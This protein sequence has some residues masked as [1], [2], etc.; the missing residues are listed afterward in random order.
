MFFWKRGC[1]CKGTNASSCGCGGGCNT[2]TLEPA[3]FPPE[4]TI[5]Y[6]RWS[7]GAENT[8]GYSTNIGSIAHDDFCDSTNTTDANFCGFCGECHNWTGGR[9]NP[10]VRYIAGGEI[11]ELELAKTVTLTL[12]D[13]TASPYPDAAPTACE[14]YY[15]GTVEEGGSLGTGPDDL[16]SCDC[17]TSY[18]WPGWMV[19][20][21]AHVEL[22]KDA[23]GKTKAK[24]TLTYNVI[25][26]G[27][28]GY[29]GDGDLATHFQG[30][31]TLVFEGVG[32]DLGEDI[33]GNTNCGYC[34]FP[35]EA[36]HNLALVSGG[37]TYPGAPPMAGGTVSVTE[38]YGDR[39]C[40]AYCGDPEPVPLSLDE[41]TVYWW[42]A[43][44][45]SAYGENLPLG[46]GGCANNYDNVMSHGVDYFHVSQCYPPGDWC[47]GSAQDPD[48]TCIGKVD[49]SQPQSVKLYNDGLFRRL[50]VSIS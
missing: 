42:L 18:T 17:D 13:G 22:I 6:T 39:T 38:S 3:E 46:E 50:N 26:S 2:G 33:N 11:D 15:R 19:C 24:V 9:G 36:W 40:S 31:G 7:L 16:M 49:T 29:C 45:V 28:T 23:T 27:T 14:A 4:I 20:F 41:W 8:T 35:W 25:D 43:S 12:Q 1:C 48:T 37:D 10:A 21:R 44:A 34:Y 47:E 32:E 5:S 30:D